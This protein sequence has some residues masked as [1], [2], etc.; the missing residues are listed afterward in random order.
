M[1]RIFLVAITLTGV[2]TFANA[3]TS[4]ST[5]TVATT[6]APSAVVAKINASAVPASLI[7]GVTV[8]IPCIESSPCGVVSSTTQNMLSAIN[9]NSTT[10]QIQAI[11]TPNF[12]FNL[13][14]RYALGNNWK[15]A[16]PDQQQQL[17]TLFKQ[18][19][20]YTY[21]S[22]VSKFKGAQITIKSVDTKEKTAAVKSEVILPNSNNNQPIV[23]EYDLAKTNGW[24]A[25]D[26]K[27]ENASLV[28]TYRNQFN[29]VIQTSKVEGLI[30]ELKSK[31]AGLQNNAK[32]Q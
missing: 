12:D 23:V 8:T 4:A 5:P 2:N 15:L 19:L 1:K 32:E 29:D 27:I 26:I 16:T 13:M 3:V 28:T 14:T 11:V 21:S 9:K 6:T 31:I 30:K 18:L 10:S 17:V 24:K 25:Y 20:I 22:A 7:G